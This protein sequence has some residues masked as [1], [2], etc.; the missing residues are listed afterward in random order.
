MSKL[1]PI[2]IDSAEP[3]VDPS[4]PVARPQVAS[5]PALRPDA[6]RLTLSVGEAAGRLGVSKATLWSLVHRGEIRSIL[7]GRRRLIPVG[8]LDQ[9]IG[10][11]EHLR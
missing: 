10:E 2:S 6:Q 5:H 3:I 8:A 7:L 1:R 11:A 4:V 9:W